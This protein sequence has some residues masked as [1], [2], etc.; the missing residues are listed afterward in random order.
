MTKS[1]ISDRIYNCHKNKEVLKMFYDE[2]QA[3][4]ACSEDPSLIFKLIKQG[5]F[6]VI[7][8]LID[9]NKIDVNLCDAVGN[10]VVTRLLKVRQYDLVLR[11][12]KKRNWNV[13]NQNYEGDTFAHILALDNSVSTLGIISQ[14][15]KKKN[16]MPNI[17]NNNGETVLDKAV[18][19][20][21][22]LAAFKILE[23][24]RFN[25]IDVLTFKKLYK[26]CIKSSSY[27]KYSSFSNLKIILENL[28]KKELIP[29]ME[30][31]VYDIKK[32]LDNIKEEIMHDRFSGLE[33]IINSSLVEATV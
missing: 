25:S 20:N 24:K 2:Q 9:E 8:N 18:N 15:V 4:N 26:S 33:S 29:S 17:K 23:D 30:K 3:Y 11:L 27:G 6:E 31:L 5:C 13:N 7:N 19:N 12:M 16:F 32:N 14:L 28:E 21:Y 1:L 10:D 22:M